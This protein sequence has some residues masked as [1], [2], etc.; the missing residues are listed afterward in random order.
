VR[1]LR[2]W[3]ILVVVLIWIGTFVATVFVG[4]GIADDDP[5]T[6]D[7]AALALPFMMVAAGLSLVYVLVRERQVQARKRRLGKTRDGSRLG[8]GDLSPP[9]QPAVVY[10]SSA[11][12]RDNAGQFALAAGLWGIA[13]VVAAMLIGFGEVAFMLGG[14]L[15]LGVL[16]V[17]HRRRSK[18]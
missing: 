18:T 4:D 15:S 6:D 13:T 14:F 11:R 8:S 7:G 5:S 12:L 16:L 10:T 2:K 9:N 3:D 17:L 1:A